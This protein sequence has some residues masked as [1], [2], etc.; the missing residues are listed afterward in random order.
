MIK[1]SLKDFVLTGRF[2][3]VT[4][5]MHKTEIIS[6]LGEPDGEND[7]GTGSSGL[8]Y[9]WYE[10]FYDTGTGILHALQND[11]LTAN[12]HYKTANPHYRNNKMYIDPW[13]IR[14]NRNITR[15]QITAILQQEKIP[16]IEKNKWGNDILIFESGV[17]MDFEDPIPDGNTTPEDFVLNGIR[18]FP[19]ML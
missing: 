10:L 18:Y 4:I 16:F 7:Y 8:N 14:Y 2:G 6:L 15:K 5:G 1:I 3:P 11:H 19:Y 13:F 12:A 17:T 9:D